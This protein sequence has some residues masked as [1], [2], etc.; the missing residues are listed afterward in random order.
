VRNT[1]V[2]ILLMRIVLTTTC[3]WTLTR[4]HG[5]DRV[6][7]EPVAR[8]LR[9]PHEVRTRSRALPAL[10]RG[11]RRA[12][13]QHLRQPDVRDA[14]EH[15]FAAAWRRHPKWVV[16]RSLESVGPNARIIRDDLENA[17]R[18][19]RDEIDGEIEVAGP[20]LAHSLTKL[21]L[22]DEYRVYLHPVVLGTGT[23]YLTEAPPLRLVSCDRVDSDVVRLKYIPA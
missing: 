17:I 3:K 19:I 16:S 18:R 8:R 2:V 11:G 1:A 7:N 14:D 10:H 4:C 23:P 6:R 22:I 12:G 15:A 20:T 13:R 9:R 5:Q 21:G